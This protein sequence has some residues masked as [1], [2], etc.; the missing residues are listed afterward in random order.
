[1]PGD[2]RVVNG[3]AV[4]AARGARA[5]LGPGLQLIRSSAATPGAPY[6]LGI[7]FPAMNRALQVVVTSAFCAA[8][9]GCDRQLIHDFS[10]DPLGVAPGEQVTLRWQTRGA[11][12]VELLPDFGDVE[13]E[14]SRSFTVTHTQTFE[15]KAW[16]GRRTSSA[17]VTVGVRDRPIEMHG[18]VV[19]SVGRPIAGAY[20]EIQRRP[21]IQTDADGRFSI[22]WITPPV[23]VVVRPPG[24]RH[25]RTSVFR[26]VA[27]STPVFVLA[28][29]EQFPPD[30]FAGVR[31][32]LMHLPAAPATG[33]RSYTTLHVFNE[34][35]SERAFHA[36][37]PPERL[38]LSGWARLPDAQ[39][40]TAE[41]FLLQQEVSE[42]LVPAKYVGALRGGPV[43]LEPDQE[44][45]LGAL[46]VAPVTSL[47][48]MANIE[49][50][51]GGTNFRVEP[52]IWLGDGAGIPLTDGLIRPTVDEVP[53][54][55]P[56]LAD[57]RF[58]VTAFMYADRGGYSTAT[59]DR[60]DSTMPVPPL[61][62]PAL[63]TL[64]APL[65]GESIPALGTLRWT[66]PFDDAICVVTVSRL[67]DGAHDVFELVGQDGEL[68]LRWLRDN[69]YV[70][71][72]P[73]HYQWRARC[74][75]E[76]LHTNQLTTAPIQFR[77]ASE[78]APTVA[79]SDWGEFEV[80]P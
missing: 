1:M 14:G 53:F 56:D 69:A 20:I 68:S 72:L 64:V 9:A 63:P 29:V 10:V 38:P 22:D 80:G 76:L 28:G 17:L 74:F 66:S 23:D 59:T 62:L 18:Q 65:Q 31:G 71:L 75:R 48:R 37:D 55:L 46:E 41:W 24:F 54:A 15:L 78:L 50:P 21:S 4:D 13:A 52:V 36:L 60:F 27:M 70:H 19:D 6:G 7:D 26:G 43:S 77:W 67:G 51:P 16:S 47:A 42:D 25:P 8:L 73:G 40:Q 11:D 5:A 58:S 49:T 57:A 39:P 61:V 12:R 3:P 32:E 33:T 34:H 35:W 79:Q 30:S 45:D 2:R 44:T